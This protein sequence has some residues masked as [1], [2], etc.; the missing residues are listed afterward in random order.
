MDD[1]VQL[2][3]GGVVGYLVGS[4]N[5]AAILARA[6]GVDL[7]GSGS[8]NPGATNTARVLGPRAGL[9]VGALDVA[10]GFVPAYVFG[11]WGGPGAAEVA[12]VAAVLGHVTSPF[13]RGHGGKGVAT[14]L[15]AILGVQPWWAVPVLL[16]F[17]AVV[18]LTHRVGLG[19]VA[20]AVTLLP[21]ALIS[22]GSGADV[23]FAAAL[24]LLVVV[25]HR[26]NLTAAWRERPWR[27]TG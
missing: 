19:A 4:V 23:A 25:R 11:R 5:P 18:L 3:L 21:V 27:S 12:G 6:R 2:A 15:G 22:H 9:L 7:R 20:G 26:S 1:W 10:K 14:A 16:V 13:L 17:G 8:G 24:T